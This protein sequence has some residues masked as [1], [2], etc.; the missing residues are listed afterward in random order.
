MHLR[1][2]HTM[3]D[4]I[5]AWFGVISSTASEV[6]SVIESKKMLW[7]LGVRTKR[8]LGGIDGDGGGDGEKKGV[9]VGT[10]HIQQ[11]TKAGGGAGRQW[12]G[13]ADRGR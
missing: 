11:S 5:C 3:G 9:N 2:P 6:G 7:V 10:N 4:D 12:G 13:G 1:H 8:R